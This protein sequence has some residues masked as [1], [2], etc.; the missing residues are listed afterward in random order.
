MLNLK[1]QVLYINRSQNT[2]S[3]LGIRT[4]YIAAHLQKICSLHV[5]NLMNKALLFRTDNLLSLLLGKLVSKLPLLPDPEL[6]ILKSYK[7]N[8]LKI[9]SMYEI[10]TAIITVLPFS[11]LLLPKYIRN[12]DPRIKII[13]DMTDPITANL[14]F[15]KYNI[16]KRNYLKRLEMNFLKYIDTL[17]V[18]NAEIRDYY[19]QK[20]PEMNILV[21]EQGFD[22]IYLS[23]N[24]RDIK[25]SE[26]VLAYAGQFYKNNRE[27][28]ELYKAIQHID[29]SI[30]LNVYGGFKKMFQPPSDQKFRYGGRISR[31]EI[32]Y[33]YSNSDILVFI[34][35]KSSIQIP[36]KLYE[37]LATNKPVLF[38][39]FD[40]DSPS[41]K[42]AMRYD[43]IFFSK[44]FYENIVSLI[45]RIID[46]GKL[47]Y[48]RD[49]LDYSWEQLL[50]KLDGEIA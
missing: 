2:N 25:K 28:F 7:K 48:N 44:N 21:I 12:L 50:K 8:V 6:L 42:L 39:Y 30:K 34:D 17:I 47:F 33:V 43:G 31:E 29:Y 36:G 11:F 38:I 18:L 41:K 4:S 24:T 10:S 9:I 20:F 35:N 49:L 40:E 16:F 27:P 46:E 26:F 13:I 19:L 14:S 23:D 3:P 37:I 45:T 15:Q 22:P 32:K 1:K 5:L